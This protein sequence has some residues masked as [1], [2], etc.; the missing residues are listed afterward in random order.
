VLELRKHRSAVGLVVVI[1]L[2][3]CSKGASFRAK[4]TLGHDAG[5]SDSSTQSGQGGESGQR[6]QGGKTANTVGTSGGG[7]TS[8]TGGAKSGGGGSG[9]ASG[10]GGST[11][12]ASIFPLTVSSNGRYLVEQDGTPFPILGDSGWEAPLNLNASDQDAYLTDR[13]GRHFNAVLFEA[14]EHKLTSNKPPKDL[15]GDL[16]FTK[17]LDGQPFTGS[18]DGTTTTSG[19]SSQFPPDPYTDINSQSPDFTSPNEPYWTAMDAYIALC[20]SKGV[21]VFMFPAYTGYGGTD[22]GWMNEMVA[23]DAVTGAGTLAGQPWVDGSKSKL[24]NYS[25]WIANRYKNATNLVWLYGGDY[26]TSATGGGL[27]T[28]PQENA[29]NSVLAGTESIASQKSILRAAH[30]AR[31]SIA[32]DVSL[33]AGPFNLESVYTDTSSAQIGRTGYAHSPAMPAFQIEGYYE[34]NSHNN[35]LPNR[36]LLWWVELSDIGGYFF[37]NEQEWGFSSGWQALLNSPGS[38][39]TARMNAFFLGIPWYQLVPS[40][41]NG[42]KTLVTENGGTENPQ[43]DDYVAAAVT[44]D[45]AVLVA[46]VPPSHSGTITVD[47]SALSKPSHARW[48]NPATAAYT[49]I[50]TNVANSSTKTFTPPGD[51]GSGFGD[52]VLVLDAR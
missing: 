29:V 44:G 37:G 17:R 49:E 27:F 15:A 42:A 30:W 52:W 50:A 4:L 2:S 51:N 40:G 6:G 45:G 24:W 48:F 16:P 33:P 19:Y 31:G 38:Q 46:Y 13:V 36:R 7:T 20:A 26:G 10:S 18:P 3:A 14:I 22:E 41:L 1:A 34:N 47:M 21:L 25:A 32:T 39:D 23:N 5:P 12:N 11:A 9:G 8:G 43:S 35:G 28:Q